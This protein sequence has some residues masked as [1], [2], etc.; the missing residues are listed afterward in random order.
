MA[1]MKA[2]WQT[3]LDSA[4]RRSFPLP[5]LRWLG[6]RACQLEEVEAAALQPLSERDRVLVR[7]CGGAELRRLRCSLQTQ[8]EL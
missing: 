2:G 5:S 7:R 4:N 3:A 1:A 6:L 8:A